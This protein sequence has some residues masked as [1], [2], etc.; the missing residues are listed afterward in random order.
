MNSE[1]G[2]TRRQNDLREV[3]SA[4]FGGDAKPHK[5]FSK[6]A[7]I[8]AAESVQGS[9]RYDYATIAFLAALMI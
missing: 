2:L 4:A 1:I 7:S 8:I 3:E 6:Y 9:E 5:G